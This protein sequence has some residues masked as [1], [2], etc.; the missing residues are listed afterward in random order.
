MERQYG[1]TALQQD[2]SIVSLCNSCPRSRSGCHER[3]RMSEGGL[4]SKRE[5][6]HRQCLKRDMQ[7]EASDAA[8]AQGRFGSRSGHRD[9][10]YRHR[11]WHRRP[12]PE[13]E[14]LPQR[15]ARTG[16]C[17]LSS[18]R[19][20]GQIWS[21]LRCEHERTCRTAVLLYRTP[22]RPYDAKPAGSG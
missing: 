2:F 8:G 7:C 3:S 21:A 18:C 14:G 15:S 6:A 9:N 5:P 1:G 16:R 10:C 12:C 20:C 17:S 4:L 13:S 19:T 11:P 22:C